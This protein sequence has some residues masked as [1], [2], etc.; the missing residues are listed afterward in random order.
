M[1]LPLPVKKFLSRD[2]LIFPVGV[3]L[4]NGRTPTTTAG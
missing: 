3:F 2:F 1:T 4:S